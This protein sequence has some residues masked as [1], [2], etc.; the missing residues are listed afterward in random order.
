MNK[1]VLSKICV[2]S[3]MI[4]LLSAG[5]VTSTNGNIETTNPKQDKTENII[6]ETETLSTPLTPPTSWIEQTKLLASDGDDG[7][8]FG[9][10]VYLDG[11][12]AIIGAPYD[13]TNGED[14]GAAYIYMRDGSSWVEIEKLLASDG[15]S[16]DEFGVAVCIDG[17]YAV[18]G[19]IED[20]DN[21]PESGSAYFFKRDG[22]AWN[23][24]DKVTAP[25]GYNGDHFGNA[26]SLNG[27]Y[28]LIGAQWK[29][30]AGSNS[31]AVYVFQRDG[32]DWNYQE[33]LTAADA[34]QD[35]NFGI[36]VSLDGEYALIG[37]FWDNDDGVHSGSAYV[38]KRDGSIWSQQ[39]KITASN[40]AEGDHFGRSV[41][42]D[43]EYAL[44]GAPDDHDDYGYAYIFERDGSN[45]NQ[46]DYFTASDIED[47]DAFGNAVS[48]DGTTA[49]IGSYGAD[50]LED[51]GSAYIFSYD[52]AA[53]TEVTKIDASDED[54]Y[55]HYGGS[56]CLDGEYALIGAREDD[57]IGD[58]SGSAYVFKLYSIPIAFLVGLIS[59]VE[60]HGEEFTRFTPTLLFMIPSDKLIYTDGTIVIKNG[61]LGLLQQTIVFALGRT[62]VIN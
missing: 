38:F 26:V 49:L 13:D 9:I 59:D 7:D 23:E 51:S 18:V 2:I 15:A 21:G 34:A 16:G 28:A 44:I 61:Y 3:I 31:G 30:D 5:I 35:D 40:A 25:D 58:D 33:K 14:A 24:Q 17:D 45:W 43:G 62:A 56:V 12:Y 46:V 57:D 22:S 8:Y 32:S 52:G 42:L 60:A 29:D 39:D 55:D 47:G 6:R 1:H 48:L 4:L 50:E 27:D 36:S 11:E 41:S 10:S 37:S 53:W 20:D 19:A 54:Y